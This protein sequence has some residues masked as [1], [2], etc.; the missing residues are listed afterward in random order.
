MQLRGSLLAGLA[1]RVRRLCIS[2]APCTL[3]TPALDLVFSPAKTQQCDTSTLHCTVF[4]CLCVCLVAL[5]SLRA[6][7]ALFFI[8]VYL[9]SI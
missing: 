6:R 1:S 5:S 4:I 9:A 7:G 2:T 3:K 8:S